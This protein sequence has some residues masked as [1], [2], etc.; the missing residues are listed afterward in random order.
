MLK[1]VTI[2]LFFAGSQVAFAQE[3]PVETGS[4]DPCIDY[5]VQFPPG[6]G[7]K[8]QQQCLQDPTRAIR[9]NYARLCQLTDKTWTI[10]STWGCVGKPLPPSHDPQPMLGNVPDPCED[11]GDAAF[12]REKQRECIDTLHGTIKVTWARV[13]KL[14]DGTWIPNL[15]WFCDTQITG[16]ENK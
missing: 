7:R 1:A 12:Q 16:S 10:N 3:Y 14:K 13:C 8:L 11:I 5:A 9:V 15:H 6:T 4:S 2:F